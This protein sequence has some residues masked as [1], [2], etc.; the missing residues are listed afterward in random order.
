MNKP[1][2]CLLDIRYVSMG[3]Q[4][5]Q[6]SVSNWPGL[7]NQ[8]IIS[9]SI[10]NTTSFSPSHR[11]HVKQLGTKS[12]GNGRVETS[13]LERINNSYYHLIEIK[14]A[15][16]NAKWA[17]FQSLVNSIETQEKRKPLKLSE[18]WLAALKRR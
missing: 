14:G 18:G 13:L 7:S 2:L 10:Q 16:I 11:Q 9:R 12:S 3:C 4:P 5:G 8:A 6:K 15:T 1:D 17:A